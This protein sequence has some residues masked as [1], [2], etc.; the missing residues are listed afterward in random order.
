[1]LLLPKTAFDPSAFKF[2]HLIY[3]PLLFTKTWSWFSGY[4]CGCSWMP[5]WCALNRPLDVHIEDNILII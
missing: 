3:V 5:I 4:H 1:M 2:G